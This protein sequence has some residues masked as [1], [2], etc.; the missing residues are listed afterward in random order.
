MKLKAE[1]VAIR[2]LIATQRRDVGGVIA[3]IREALDTLPP[4]HP[5]RAVLALTL[6]YALSE[7]GDAVAAGSAFAEAVA[8]A[9]PAKNL[10]VATLAATG[11]GQLALAQDRLRA[12]ADHHRRALRFLSEEG[13]A[14]WPLAG[15]VEIDLGLVLRER[16]ELEAASALIQA[17]VEK[18]SRLGSVI[19]ELA[20][21]YAMSRLRSAQGD[22]EAALVALDRA[23][24]RVAGR[25]VPSWG[26]LIE[27]HRA[28]LGLSSGRIDAAITWAQGLDPASV[29]SAWSLYLTEQLMLAR[30]SLARGRPA[31][32][33]T[34]LSPI[35]PAIE[36]DGRT[37]NLAE[38]LILEALTAYLAGRAG[39]TTTLL[40]QALALAAPEGHIRLFLDE[41]PT[42][43][44]LLR[45]ARARRGTR[46]GRRAA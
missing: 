24:E 22:W 16:N 46:R 31:E 13:G 21:D 43:I 8:V 38:I 9:R 4:Q 7:L 12:A 37:G 14:A 5:H 40:A 44:T 32:A 1:M 15:T 25:P 20:G 23:R 11:H 17:G 36:R 18:V 39:A 6:G 45:R 3:L 19:P 29:S 35:R 28:R 42:L 26:A 33:A 10:L 2:A 27:A 30:L 41:G 34:V